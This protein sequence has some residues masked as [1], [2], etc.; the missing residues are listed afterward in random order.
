MKNIKKAGICGKA[1]SR[2][3]QQ[4][5]GLDPITGKDFWFHSECNLNFTLYVVGKA[6][7]SI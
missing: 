4:E 2:E 3:A 6:K 5:A 1:V 7:N